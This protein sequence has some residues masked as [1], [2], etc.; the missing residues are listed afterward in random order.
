MLGQATQFA[1]VA[2]Q[3]GDRLVPIEQ[4][5][6]IL[7]YGEFWDVPRIFVVTVPHG[8]LVFES[9]FDEGLDDY[10]PEYSVYFLPWSEAQRLHGLWNTLTDGAELR[11]RIPVEDV[12]FDKTRR[13]MVSRSVV[14]RFA[15]PS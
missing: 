11:G 10:P 13:L 7:S 2:A 1:L 6:R 9:P 8:M 14:E 5:T 4:L 15:N 12:E 3:P